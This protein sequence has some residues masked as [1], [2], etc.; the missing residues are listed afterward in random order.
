MRFAH[1]LN[2]NILESPDMGAT[3]RDPNRVSFNTSFCIV[4]LATSACAFWL[5]RNSD[6]LTDRHTDLLTY[7]CM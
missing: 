1:L 7:S 3:E 6:K 5:K 4:E 2:D